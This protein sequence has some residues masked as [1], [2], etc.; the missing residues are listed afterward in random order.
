MLKWNILLNQNVR[1]SIRC[2]K[3]EQRV[4]TICTKPET[5]IKKQEKTTKETTLANA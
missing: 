2:T 4:T 3:K 5:E 1:P